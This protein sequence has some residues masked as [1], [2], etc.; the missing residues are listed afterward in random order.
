MR[1][2]ISLA[3]ESS[4]IRIFPSRSSMADISWAFNDF[5]LIM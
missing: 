1:E 5:A 4:A 3:P 2:V